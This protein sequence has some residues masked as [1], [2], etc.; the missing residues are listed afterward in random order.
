MRTPTSERQCSGRR[1]ATLLEV[2]IAMVIIALVAAG[3]M[4]AFVFSRRATWRSGT[5]LSAAVLAQQSADGLRLAAATGVAPDGLLLAPGIY[6]DDSMG[7]APAG[8]TVLVPAGG[9]PNPLNFPAEFTR[10]QTD[11]GTAATLEGHGDGRLIVVENAPVD[12][13]VPPNGIQADELALVDLDGDSL[14][15]QDFNGDGV[16]DLRRVR[17]RVRWTTPTA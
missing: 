2:I 16:T 8:S 4:G 17:I 15:G 1:G 9:G 11:G 13:D 7:N 6:V 5:E 3:M 12:T 10:F 14:A